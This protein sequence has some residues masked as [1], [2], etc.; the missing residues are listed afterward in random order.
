MVQIRDG[1]QVIPS[2]TVAERYDSNVLLQAKS[3]GIDQSDYVSALAPQIRGLYK[4]SAMTVN[5]TVGAN[6][7]Y[8]VKNTDFSYVGAN[9]GLSL[10][11]SPIFSRLWN[12]MNLRVFDSF[13][14][15]PQPPSFL[16]G[17]QEGDTSNPFLTGQLVG[18]VNST[19]NIVGATLTAPLTQTLSL[20][21][22]Y[23]YGFLQFGTSQ[24]QQVGALLDSAYQIFTVGM[25]KMLS[26][27]NSVSLNYFD[28]E[29]R[30]EPDDSFS[31]R[32]GFIRWQHLFSQSATLDSSIGATV[33][34]GQS[35]GSDAQ[36]SAGHSAGLSN[37]SSTVAPLGRVALTWGDS[38]TS[39]TM[40]YGVG[41]S[42]SFQFQAQ[43]LFTNVVTLSVRQQTLIP[44][45]LG[46]A[47]ASYGRGDEIGSNSVSGV[48]YTSYVASG[49]VLYKFT[50]QTFINL[51]YLYANYDSQFG[52]TNN[53]FDRHVVSIS[54]A[55]AFY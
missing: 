24:V 20:T 11:L 18:R 52:A 5:A 8:F 32:G 48:S 55:Q 10:D 43:P 45:L 27:R 28:S 35:P 1:F 16:V 49:G 31:N 15:T 4:G 47:S 40:A 39:L 9:A 42:P 13:R 38:T 14:Y 7:E 29:Y 21:G 53:S 23:S 2:I 17:N 33:V 26:N 6:A 12:G 36:G 34:Q 51:T 54:L 22:G 25:L 19:S 44:E 41:L 46:L 30:Y 3:P 37:I 50:P